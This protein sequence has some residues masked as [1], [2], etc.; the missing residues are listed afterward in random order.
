MARR[1]LP[2]GTFWQCSLCQ[3]ILAQERWLLHFCVELT[4]SA[5]GVLMVIITFVAWVREPKPEPPKPNAVPVTCALKPTNGPFCIVSKPLGNCGEGG[6]VVWMSARSAN[7]PPTL[8]GTSVE[9]ISKVPHWPFAINSGKLQVFTLS[10][11]TSLPVFNEPPE[12]LTL[13]AGI[14]PKLESVNVLLGPAS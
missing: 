2:P 5:Y 13:E 8:A 6:N 11:T 1:V 3:T 9:V 7:E 10:V 12:I 14:E 4:P